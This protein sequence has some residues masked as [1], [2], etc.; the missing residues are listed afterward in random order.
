[1]H[2]FTNA[3][4]PRLQTHF[5]TEVGSFLRDRYGFRPAQV[6]SSESRRPRFPKC[7]YGR[8]C[9]M[10]P[11]SKVA[12]LLTVL[13]FLCAVLPLALLRFMPPLPRSKAEK[14]IPLNEIYGKL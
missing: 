6:L 7:A 9:G 1:M 2:Q 10:R 3:S 12:S 11:K 5:V 14:D 13:V 4:P 8:V